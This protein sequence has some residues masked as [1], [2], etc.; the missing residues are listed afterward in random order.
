MYA[1]IKNGKFLSF[2]IASFFS[3]LPTYRYRRGNKAPMKT[4]GEV[5]ALVGN[6]KE[7]VFYG[8]STAES[9]FSR[10]YGSR[11]ARGIVRLDDEDAGTG[12]ST[13]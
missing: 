12:P 7:G 10:S 5:T 1:K 9:V 4:S 8:I 2:K 13:S 3:L 11:S 6:K